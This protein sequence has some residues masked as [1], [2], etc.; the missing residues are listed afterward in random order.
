MRTGGCRCGAIR[1][2]V[3]GEPL[4]GIACHCRDC[5]YAAGG[6]AN[7][8]W[9][10]AAEAL[11]VVRGEPNCYQATAASGGTFFCNNCGVQLYS[12][13]DKN[14]HLVAIKIGAMD[15]A[16]GFSIQADMWMAS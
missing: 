5:Q 3:A 9:I 1:F 12:R 10:F 15:S 14:P 6:S 11:L 8:S 16:A 13:P 4:G 2:T 7:L